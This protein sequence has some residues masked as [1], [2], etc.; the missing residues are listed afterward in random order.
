MVQLCLTLFKDGWNFYAHV[1]ILK[2]LQAIDEI[3]TADCDTILYFSAGN[4]IDHV[5][6]FGEN[7]LFFIVNT[8]DKR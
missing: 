5:L 1:F 4:C 6:I 7:I 2:V 8:V 3:Y